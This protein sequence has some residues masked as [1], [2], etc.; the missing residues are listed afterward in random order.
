MPIRVRLPGLHRA[1]NDPSLR[2]HPGDIIRYGWFPQV[3]HTGD[4]TP[5]EWRVLAEKDGHLLLL[6]DMVLTSMILMKLPGF[7]SWW[8]SECRKW[9]NRDF[10]GLAFGLPDAGLL[11]CGIPGC[12]EDRVFLLNREEAERY[13][14]E[15]EDRVCLPTD[16]A[17]NCVDVTRHGERGGCAW[18]L[19]DAGNIFGEV[20]CVQPDG[21][22]GVSSGTMGH[23]GIRPAVWMD[24]AGPM[25]PQWRIGRNDP[26]KKYSHILLMD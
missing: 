13:L 4:R 2:P 3:E 25:R 23:I 18:W 19:R 11:P 6:S 17:A 26:E 21:A 9:L 24:P 22:F 7:F 14:P 5:I 10:V 20:R 8:L 15:T 12:E 1:P 16:Y